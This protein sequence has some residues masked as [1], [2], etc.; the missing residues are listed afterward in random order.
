MWLRTILTFALVLASAGSIPASQGSPGAPLDVMSFNIRY[1]TANDGE[2]RWEKQER[3]WS[4]AALAEDAAGN[5]LFIFSR[6]P[7]SMFEFNEILLSLPLEIT[8]A[9][10]LEGGPEAQL[11]Y[12]VGERSEELV[13]SFETGFSDDGNIS[14][15]PI[16]NVIVVRKK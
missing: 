6:K 7:Y 8:R 9:Q 15:W 12:R 1:G 14:A 11:F 4:E 10:H 3:Q 16:P 5:A 13:G 2:N